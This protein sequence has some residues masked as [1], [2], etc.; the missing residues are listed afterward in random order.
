MAERRAK[1]VALQE[2]LGSLREE[3]QAWE[4]TVAALE[5]KVRIAERKVVWY[6]NL[7]D[8]VS[9]ECVARLA[10]GKDLPDWIIAESRS[11]TELI[12]ESSG[13]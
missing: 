6:E 9:S 13:S 2:E 5:L 4:K 8:W 12:A 7:R 10:Y 3:K 1:N 11:V